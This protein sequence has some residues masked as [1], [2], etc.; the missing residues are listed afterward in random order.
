MKT[1]ILK[2][3]QFEGCPVIIRQIGKGMFEYLLVYE[4]QFYGTFIDNQ[5][6]WWNPKRYKKEPC[7]A[8]EINAMIHFLQ[9]AAEA[10]IETK[11]HEKDENRNN[12]QDKKNILHK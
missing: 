8:N 7:T 2:Q 6:P 12:N 1:K 5:I 3:Y 10:T 4:S 9:K 11:K